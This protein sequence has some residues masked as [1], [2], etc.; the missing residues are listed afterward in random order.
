VA[1]AGNP[2]AWWTVIG[3]VV[4]TVMLTKVLGSAFQDKYMGDRPEYREVMARTRAFLPLPRADAGRRTSTRDG[5]DAA[6]AA[7]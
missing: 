3:P 5:T 7:S 4:N 1:L 6:S 2:D